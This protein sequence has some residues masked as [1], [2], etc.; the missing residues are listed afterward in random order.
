MVREIDAL[1]AAE[2]ERI[3]SAF[4]EME[5]DP[6]AGDIKTLKGLK[7]VFRRRVG[8]YRVAFTVNF[9]RDEV[10]ILRVGHRSKFYERM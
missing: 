2:R 8:D 3:L 1:P 4:R 9:E 6:F 5:S 10:I 7:G